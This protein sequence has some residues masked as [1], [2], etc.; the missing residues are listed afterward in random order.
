M[1]GRVTVAE[2]EDGLALVETAPGVTVED[3][4]ERPA[5][6]SFSFRTA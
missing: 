1:A 6:P 3:I 2:V 4:T 5:A